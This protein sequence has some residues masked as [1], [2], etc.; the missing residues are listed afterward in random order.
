MPQRRYPL[1][2]WTAAD[3]DNGLTLESGVIDCRTSDP[4]GMLIR[5]TNVGGTANIKIQVCFSNDGTTFND[6]AAQDDIVDASA[7]F[8]SAALEDYHMVN[9]PWAPYLKIKLTDLLLADDTVV[10]AVLWMTEL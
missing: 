7:T 5:V 10:D 4:E 2:L 1:R 8:W 9:I 6:Y 3:L